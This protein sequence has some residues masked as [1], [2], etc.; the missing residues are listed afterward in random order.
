MKNNELANTGKVIRF[1][2]WSGARVKCIC[3]VRIKAGEEYDVMYLAHPGKK[4]PEKVGPLHTY[5]M[6]RHFWYMSIERNGETEG[7]A[8]QDEPDRI[9]YKPEE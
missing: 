7:E 6:D 2:L 9:E 1:T 8:E 4:K 5:C 3:G